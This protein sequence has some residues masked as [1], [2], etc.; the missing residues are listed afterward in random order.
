MRASSLNSNDVFVIFGA[1]FL[2]IWCGKV[3]RILLFTRILI[4]YYLIFFFKYK[5]KILTNRIEP[6]REILS[7]SVRCDKVG[8]YF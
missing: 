3:I 2:Y 6:F 5:C 7:F 1:R 4:L 8:S